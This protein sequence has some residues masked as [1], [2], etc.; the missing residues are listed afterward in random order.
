MSDKPQVQQVSDAAAVSAGN[1]RV[2]TVSASMEEQL[3]RL[4]TLYAESAK[5]HPMKQMGIAKEAIGLTIELLGTMAEHIHQL[6]GKQHD[7]AG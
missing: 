2:T 3:K 5:A 7:K 1:S 4:T 6:E